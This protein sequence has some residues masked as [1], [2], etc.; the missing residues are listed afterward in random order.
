[1]TR[2]RLRPT[3]RKYPYVH[4]VFTFSW[5]IVQTWHQSC[6]LCR[7]I[8]TYHYMGGYMEALTTRGEG[9][10]LNVSVHYT[11]K[12]TRS[13]LAGVG[14]AG[15][16]SVTDQQQGSPTKGL[17]IAYVDACVGYNASFVVSEAARQTVIRKQCR[18]VHAKVFCQ[19]DLGEAVAHTPTTSVHYNPY[20]ASTFTTKTGQPI[21]AADRVVF[22]PN[23]CYI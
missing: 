10:R 20:R 8:Q 1:M 21:T 7:H 13:R 23:G 22:S 6:I 19:V 17:V 14:R 16:Y 11:L 5:Q 3:L 18:S 9:A 4:W 2:A 15:Q 12:N